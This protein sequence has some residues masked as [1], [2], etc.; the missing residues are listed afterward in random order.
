LIDTIFGLVVASLLVQR[1]TIPLLGARLL[2]ARDR[3][4]TASP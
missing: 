3:A 2:A 4:A 1:L